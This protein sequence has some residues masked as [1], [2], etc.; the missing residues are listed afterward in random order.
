MGRL[1]LLA[2]SYWQGR[3]QV[4]KWPHTFSVESGHR[5]GVWRRAPSGVDPGAK[6][7]SGWGEDSRSWKPSH[8]LDTPRKQQICR[9]LRVLQ[10]GESSPKRDRLPIPV[11]TQRI[12]INHRNR[13]PMS[14]PV[15]LKTTPLHTD[16]WLTVRLSAIHMQSTT[17]WCWTSLFRTHLV[18]FVSNSI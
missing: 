9:I 6:P 11:K 4:K 17:R 15:N 14:T 16:N 18:S 2:R 7:L 1:T 12:C 5:T 8:L 13:N 10:T 3:R